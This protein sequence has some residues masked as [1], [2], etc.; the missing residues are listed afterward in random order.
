MDTPIISGPPPRSVR[1]RKIHPVSCGKIFAALY[2]LG[3]LL[4]VPFIIF[5]IMLGISTGQISGDKAFSPPVMMLFCIALPF[6]YG[7]A[8]FVFGVIAASLYNLVARFLGG[9]EVE[10]E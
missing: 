1:L 7:L 10:I 6:A 5:G 9:L 3:T 8:G 4:F 2:A